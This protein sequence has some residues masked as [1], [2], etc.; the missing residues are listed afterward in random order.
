MCL[1]TKVLHY[2]SFPWSNE[3]SVESWFMVRN[4][5]IRFS[6]LTCCVCKA[7]AQAALHG[8]S[9]IEPSVENR[10]RWKTAAVRLFVMHDNTAMYATIKSDRDGLRKFYPN[11]VEH[12]LLQTSPESS[13]TLN[14]RFA[15]LFAQNPALPGR[16]R[17]SF[18]ILCGSGV[19]LYWV[20]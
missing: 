16:Q 10:Y 8:Y 11:H 3:M 14:P 12:H 18:H 19:Y 20:A 2:K 4:I 7:D 17:I 9:P 15:N 13:E 6:L 1:S 5:E